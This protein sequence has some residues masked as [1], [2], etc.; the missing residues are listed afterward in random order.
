MTETNKSKVEAYELTKQLEEE[1]IE[2]ANGEIINISCNYKKFENILIE[3]LFPYNAGEIGEYASNLR[4]DTVMEALNRNKSYLYMFPN[5]KEAKEIPIKKELEITLKTFELLLD[6]YKN[7]KNLT[8]SC[9]EDLIE[10]LLVYFRRLDVSGN[11]IPH[12]ATEETKE[13]LHLSVTTGPENFDRPWPD[14]AKMYVHSVYLSNT[15]PPKSAKD[16]FGNYI[17]YDLRPCDMEK[18]LEDCADLQDYFG[19]HFVRIMLDRLD[20]GDFEKFGYFLLKISQERCTFLH[21]ILFP[22]HSFIRHKIKAPK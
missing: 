18:I 7:S 9:A 11:L 6:L 21:N 17:L 4:H 1:I 15:Y 13:K 14:A 16:T 19:A 12:W 8:L 3:K 10:T 22:G 20:V 5:D 2:V